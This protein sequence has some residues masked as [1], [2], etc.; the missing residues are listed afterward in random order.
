MTSS[1]KTKAKRTGTRNRQMDPEPEKPYSRWPWPRGRLHPMFV[2]AVQLVSN[3]YVFTYFSYL[4]GTLFAELWLGKHPLHYTPYMKQE[5]EGGG[6]GL[7]GRWP[8]S[9]MLYVWIEISHKSPLTIQ[10][11]WGV[12]GGETVVG[13]YYMRE[14]S[15]FNKSLNFFSYVGKKKMY[16]KIILWMKLD[17]YKN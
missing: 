6:R 8:W 3:L 15:I 14:E 12:E 9:M 11:E 4:W 10:Q 5:T 7:K 2:G 16:L 13:M 1:A 17:Y